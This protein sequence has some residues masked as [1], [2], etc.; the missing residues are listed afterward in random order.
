MYYSKP[1][2]AVLSFLGSNATKLLEIHSHLK[3][4]VGHKLKCLQVLTF[5]N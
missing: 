1:N 4:G 3:T 2:A 5:M